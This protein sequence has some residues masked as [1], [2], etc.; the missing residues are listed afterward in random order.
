MNEAEVKQFME[1][2]WTTLH[3]MPEIGNETPR[4][5]AYLAQKLREYGY[6]VDEDVAGGVVAILDSGRK[7]VEFAL[8]SD[9][10]ALEFYADGEKVNYHGCCHDGHMSIVLAAAKQLAEDGIKNGRLWI[11]FQPGEEPSTGAR[12]MIE[13]GKLDKIEEMAG[14]HLV[15]PDDVAPGRVASLLLH[16]GLGTVKAVISGR[17]AHAS[18]PQDGIN[19]AE[20]A[21]LAVNA[22]NTIRC[23]PDKEWSCK[24][25]QISADRSSDNTIPD[26]AF[27]AFDLRAENNELLKMLNEKLQKAVTGAVHSIGAEVEFDVNLN[28]A[29]DYDEELADLVEKEIIGQLGAENCAGR[30][31]TG[32]GEDF[33]FYSYLKGIKTAYMAIGADVEPALHIYRN[34]F[35]HKYLYTGYRLLCAIAHKKLG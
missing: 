9:T 14:L 20:A 21:V 30:V 34:T 28:P 25:T 12:R 16:N 17:N 26:Y 4:T 2:T 22:A 11:V 5:C 27:L 8:R 6:S 24:V 32:C 1:D 18:M 19:A 35:D 33:H 13:T 31:H 15:P 23:A 29:P 7:G 10:D 3:Q